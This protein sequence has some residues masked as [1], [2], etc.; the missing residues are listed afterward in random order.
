MPSS[1]TRIAKNTLML[2]FRQIL[3]MLVS[4]YTVRVVLETLGA[5]DYGIYNVVAGVTGMFSFLSGSMSGATQRFFAYELGKKEAG[6]YNAVFSMCFNIYILIGILSIILLETIGLWL[7]NT[8][9]VIPADRM[10]AA[11]F[12]YQF[13]VFSFVL[14]IL[15]TVY[16]ATIIS[17]ERM[18]IF[19]GISIVDAVL[20]LAIV[21][22]LRFFKADTLKI[23]AV[24]LFSVS[25]IH[26]MLYLML[27]R[28]LFTDCIYKL[29]WNTKLFKE[30]AEYTGWN[31][32]GVL[33]DMMRNH[34]INILLNIFYGP[35]VNAARGIAF[36]IHN[37]VKTLSNNSYTSIRPR[38]TKL[39]AEKNA[40]EMLSLFFLGTRAIF[41]L[42]VFLSIPIF[43][44][45]PFILRLWL[46]EVPDYTIL[47]TRL[48]LIE[49]LID[50][51]RY[52]IQTIVFAAGKVRGFQLLV[53]GIMLLQLPISYIFLGLGFSPQTPMIIAIVIAVFA[54][55][56]RLIITKKIM[57]FPLKKYYKEILLKFLVLPV[58]IA[59][60]PGILK[61]ILPEG[62]IQFFTVCGASV[63]S[64]ILV[65][66]FLDLKKEE[67]N[68]ISGILKLRLKIG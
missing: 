59:I 29:S 4:L 3:I 9:L 28:K 42:M 2:Y 66:Y 39:Y 12:L 36:Q 38:I 27:C 22:F 7:L 17:H 1:T 45:V 23:Y 51:L 55:C 48:I 57:I 58:L 21:F 11:R 31:T 34:G 18:G 65:I 41:Y 40:K 32:L 20:K 61:Y 56:G 13:V 26:F 30:I 33:A 52:P 25:C 62:I 44:E 54:H 37:V 50:C 35:L 14:Q 53:S 68:K 10:D 16:T 49:A 19:A 64:C 47:F 63:I 60:P 46:R 5:E 8:K 24:L 15:T 6:Q 67:R 43:F